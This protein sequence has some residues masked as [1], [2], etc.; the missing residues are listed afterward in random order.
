MIPDDAYRKLPEYLDGGLLPHEREEIEKLFGTS[1]ELRKALRTSIALEAM[2]RGQAWLQPPP[3]FAKSV[4]KRALA[5]VPPRVTAWEQRW[6]RI[7]AGLSVGTLA[8]LLVFAHHPL[9]GWGKAAL[10][11]A[12]VWLGSLTGLTVFALH[13]V[14]VLGVLAPAVAGGVVGCILSGRC[15][16]SSD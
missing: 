10:N 12:G 2:L 6:E 8:L 3:K 7:R 5:E 1:P 9:A 16:L 4:L 15:R 14:A 13:P 11:G